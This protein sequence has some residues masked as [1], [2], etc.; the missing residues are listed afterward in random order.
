M[1]VPIIALGI[2][3]LRWK[4]VL[5][6]AATPTVGDMNIYN[7]TSMGVGFIPVLPPINPGGTTGGVLLVGKDPNDTTTHP[8]IVTCS[9]GEFFTDGSTSLTLN[10]SGQSR[11]LQIVTYGTALRWTITGGVGSP[12]ILSAATEQ[13]FLPL[14]IALGG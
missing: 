14:I 9:P 4:P 6:T 13:S 2:G 10:D 5:L 1:T 12:T 8:I 11:T 3:P 7:T